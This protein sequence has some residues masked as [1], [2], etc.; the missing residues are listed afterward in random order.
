M[1]A[2]GEDTVEFDEARVV[3]AGLVL[4]CEVRGRRVGIPTSRLAPG[5]EVWKP[6]DVGKLVI[7]REL[8]RD[9]G[10]L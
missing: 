1:P 8:A 7:P 6:G 5:N 2:G 10:L 3:S 9:L 4:I